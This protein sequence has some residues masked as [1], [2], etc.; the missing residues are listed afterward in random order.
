M[1]T[2]VQTGFLK[3]MRFRGQVESCKINRGRTRNRYKF[4]RGTNMLKV[5]KPSELPRG[6][7]TLSATEGI[8]CDLF[9][10]VHMCRHVRCTSRW[11]IVMPIVLR[12]VVPPSR[13]QVFRDGSDGQMA[14]LGLAQGTMAASRGSVA[15]M[16]GI[17]L[18]LV[19]YVK[20]RPA[21]SG[22]SSVMLILLTYSDSKLIRLRK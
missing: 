9:V 10:Y 14:D 3:R 1:R 17:L 22:Y 5:R 4:L 18:V 6:A 2:C 12:R 8:F 19:L 15:E 20:H 7:H 16:C 13:C 11:H 21:S